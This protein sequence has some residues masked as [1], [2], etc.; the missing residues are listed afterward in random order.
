M[1]NIIDKIRK[2]KKGQEDIYILL[3]NNEITKVTYRNFVKE[4]FGNKSFIIAEKEAKYHYTDDETGWDDCFHYTETIYIY[5][6]QIKEIFLTEKEKN[7]FFDKNKENKKGFAIYVRFLN[8]YEVEDI[9]NGESYTFENKS[10]EYIYFSEQEYSTGDKILINEKS[11][12]VT[13]VEKSLFT[14]LEKKIKMKFGSHTELKQ[15]NL[16]NN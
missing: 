5:L 12:I 11:A 14:D 7:S 16:K 15:I 13:K 8:Y 4:V 1:E 6:S 9:Y 3:K 2:I 10:A